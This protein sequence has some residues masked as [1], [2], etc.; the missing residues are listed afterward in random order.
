MITK[1]ELLRIA[2]K[3]GFRNPQI[4]EKDYALTWALNAIYANEKLGKYLVF[5]GGT[6][7]SKVYAQGYRMSEDLDFSAYK[8]G[9]LTPSEL[10]S[11]LEKAFEEANKNGAPSLMLKK[12]E[13]HQNPGLLTFQV[14]Y[15]GPLGNPNRIKIELSS[16]E[17]VKYI[18]ESHPINENH[19]PDIRQF[20]I[21]CYHFFEL[22]AEKLRAIMQRG[23]S[24]DY[25]D[26][27]QMLK[28]PE[29][30]KKLP[31]YL[32]ELQDLFY[33]KCYFNSVPYEPENIF[34][35][36][37][38]EGAEKYWEQGL[39]YLVKELPDFKTVIKELKNEFFGEAELAEFASDWNFEHLLDIARQD[40]T[41]HLMGRAVEIAFERCKSKKRKETLE[42]LRTL[43]SMIMN[44]NYL[45]YVKNTRELYQGIK[46]LS[47]D[48]DEEVKE[49][50]NSLL[51]L[52]EKK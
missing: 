48:K 51:N 35:K 19:Y 32:F 38:I 33:E 30:R 22:F 52:L 7:L 34:S 46:I 40:N 5:K 29:L 9:Q 45:G 36:E 50:A 14:K 42:G 43:I 27:W 3:K 16:K 39:G 12:E 13:T 31:I 37:K 15:T 17:Y 41:N 25:Y 1:E 8:E 6:C 4:V 11:E 21:H 2:A 23:K 49:Q 10:E 20:N 26:V 28:R 44:K 18:S 47:D 24:R